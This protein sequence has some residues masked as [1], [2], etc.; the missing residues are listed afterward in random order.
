MLHLKC[1]NALICMFNA[2]SKVHSDVYIYTHAFNMS[3]ANR[4]A[5]ES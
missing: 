2:V 4:A 5:T 1:E 3:S